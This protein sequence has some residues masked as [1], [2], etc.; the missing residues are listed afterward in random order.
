M[1]T[2][3]DEIFEFSSFQSNLN[4]QL[5]KKLAY[6]FLKAYACEVKWQVGYDTIQLCLLSQSLV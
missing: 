5:F 2:R 6:L 4:A 1:S 3:F